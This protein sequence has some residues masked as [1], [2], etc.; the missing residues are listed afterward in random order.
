MFA[1]FS[2]AYKIGLA[3]LGLLLAAVL[4]LGAFPWD[5]LAGSMKTRLEKTV[6]GPV[7]F[8][9]V[10]RI[11]S[12]S[13]HPVIEVRGLTVPGPEWAGPEKLA[14]VGSAR[15]QF[16]AWQVLIGRFRLDALILKDT[17]LALVRRRDGLESWTGRKSSDNAGGASALR[18]L[19][20]ANSTVTY[21]D[22]RQDRS[23]TVALEASAKKGIA[24]SGHGEIHGKPIRVKAVGAPIGADGEAS[25]PYSATIE[26]DD[27][28][29]TISGTMPKPLDVAHLSGR[30][31]ARASDLVLI[32]AIIEAGL[33]ATQPVSLTANVERN[34]RDWT[35]KDL[36]GTV[37]RSDVAGSATIVKRDGRTRIDGNVHAK[38]FDF[39]DLSSVEGLRIAASKRARFGP[40]VV[41]DTAIDL[42]TVSK[43]DGRLKITADRLLWREP[44]PIISLSATLDLER[45]LLTLSHVNL[46]LAR[47]SMGGSIMVDQRRGGPRLALDL[48]LQGARLSDFFPGAGID[49]DLRGRLK[50]NGIGRTVRNAVAT[51]NGAFSL[52]SGQ[53]QLPART[54]S[55]LGQDIGRS[56]TTSEDAMAELRCVVALFRVN[57][58]RAQAS[59]V[60]VDT[61]RAKTNVIGEIDLGTE[62][63]S[64]SMTGAPKR[65]SLLRLPGAVTVKG[66]IKVPAITVPKSR[67]SVGG[68]LKM[69]GQAITG[70]QAPLADDADCG[71][72]SAQALA[73]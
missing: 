66:T 60:V 2:L 5:L 33:P 50:L 53:G 36:K 49:A 11:D 44:S 40:R 19:R 51:S 43:T 12:F 47:G 23:F 71:H 52:V 32:D 58:G 54:A 41:P 30:V 24:A 4:L 38:Q 70:K 64:L 16:S 56:L 20:I 42:A 57:A 46:G 67:R 68:I 61:S 37:G 39:E 35:V 63:L 3:A 73:I 31:S 25:W 17:H 72:L 55:L 10:E 48:T 21:R 62:A 59:E 6:G 13:F 69:L 1:K 9:A 18:V 27:V 22:A 26:G 28:A 7:T 45:S 34:R 14:R 65:G 15:V 8:A 29:F